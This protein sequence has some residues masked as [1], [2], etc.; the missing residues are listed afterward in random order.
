MIGF[1]KRGDGDASAVLYDSHVAMVY[2]YFR[3]CGVREADDLTSEVFV[4]MLRGLNRFDG[5]HADFRRWLMTIAHRRLVDYRRRMTANRLDYV[6]PARLES[7]PIKIDDPFTVV[8]D[9]ALIAGLRQLTPAQQEILALRFVAD[10]SLEMVA[11][12]TD[13]SVGAVKSMQ[14]RALAMLRREL[15][16]SDTQVK[17]EA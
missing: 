7:S 4:G 8:V 11:E 9:P 2:G 5:H 12:I 13:R 10:L 6:T 1:A 3:A 17:R 16:R 14:H 15:V